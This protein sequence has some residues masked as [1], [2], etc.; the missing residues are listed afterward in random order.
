MSVNSAPF[1]NTVF[2]DNKDDKFETVVLNDKDLNK[3]SHTTGGG[4]ENLKI[5]RQIFRQ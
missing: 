2:S 1:N 4:F 5:N 3:T